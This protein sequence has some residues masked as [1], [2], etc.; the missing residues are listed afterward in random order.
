MAPFQH[1]YDRLPAEQHDEEKDVQ[2]L[3]EAK[4]ETTSMTLPSSYSKSPKLSVFLAITAVSF[5]IFALFAGLGVGSSSFS[6]SPA[7]SEAS[8]SEQVSHHHDNIPAPLARSTPAGDKY[9]IGVGKAD[10]TGPVVELNL[11]GYAS[12][13]QTGTGLR[14]R[15]YSRAFI[16]GDVDNPSDRFVYLILDAQSGDSAVRLGILEGIAA[17]GEE[18][19]VYSTSNIAVTGT[20]QHSGP[21]AWFNYLL[22]QVTSLGFSKQ[23]YQ[24]LVDGGVLSVKRAHESLTEG[25]LD[26][27]TTN[28]TDGNLS[29]SLYAYMANPASERALYSDTTD[30][31]MT[32]VRMQRASDLKNIGVLSWYPVHGTSMLENNTHVTGDNKGVAAYL[33]EQ[34]MLADTNAAPG[35]VAGFSQANVGDTTPNTLGAYCDDGSGDMCSY[36]NSTC[37]D[38]K[39]ESCHGRGPEFQKLDLGVSSCL[40]IGRRQYAGALAIYDD[41]S[42]APTPVVGSTVKSYHFYQDMRYFQFQLPN[43]TAVQTCP[44]ALGYS[45]AAGTSDGPG[46]FDFTQADSGS[47][48]ANPLWAVVSGLLK[49]PSAE[50]KACQSPKPVLLDV[51]E[52]TEPYAWSPNIV[53][54]QTLRVGQLIIII[55]P[56]EATTMSGR[57]WRKAVHDEAKETFLKGGADPIVVLGGPANVYAH[58][59]ATP[60]E[61]GI[62]R[63]EGASTLYG[64]QQLPAYINLTLS[65]LHYLA[66]DATGA[67]A[68]GPAPPDNRNSSLSF[69]TGVFFDAAP[70]GSSFG[71]CT[72]QPNASYTRGQVVNATFTG[73]NPRN[74]LRLEGTF[75]AVEKK[76]STDGWTQVRSDDDWTLVYTWE[77]TNTA[78][79]YSEVTLSWESEPT[80]TPGTYRLKYYGDSK[81]LIGSISAF[82]GT[83]NAFTLS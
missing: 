59:C 57:R 33:F 1:T 50:Q 62:Q 30:K 8:S 63:Y 28:I 27:G 55:S 4:T 68:A 45:F 6:H 74:N 79:G 82:T 11:A 64:Q 47:P 46:A 66:P 19:S 24:A 81:P 61:Y 15:T 49:A 2:A 80:A 14:Q 39:S 70:I 22:P 52:M 67:P 56:S 69:I 38:G 17:L 73:A 9:L 65:N 21:G 25:Y 7:S 48:D 41:L 20:H 75:A 58:Y 83:S 40:E 34:A 3:S 60:E 42:K 44:A 53:D 29:R 13:D 5:F 72:S 71:Q 16:V 32:L 77:R 37:A 51:G 31:T 12:L 35:F 18:Y 54:M 36:E 78:L 43:G 23:S 10:I 76:N 26:V